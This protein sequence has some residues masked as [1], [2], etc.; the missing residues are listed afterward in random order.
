MFG[1]KERK[2]K[3]EGE[4]RKGKASLRVTL[5]I[6]NANGKGSGAG[7]EQHLMLYFYKILYKVPWHRS[8]VVLHLA[9]GRIVKILLNHEEIHFMDGSCQDTT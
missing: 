2:K 5:N 4:E 3:R 8:L 6:S 1:G 9:I 7:E